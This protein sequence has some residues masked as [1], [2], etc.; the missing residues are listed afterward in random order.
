MTQNE[1]YCIINANVDFLKQKMILSGVSVITNDYNSTKIVFNFTNELNGTKIA[2]IRKEDSETTEALFAGEI[3]N[4][5]VILVAKKDVTT[6]HNE[7]TYTKYIDSQENIYWYNPLNEK[8]YNEEFV[9]QPSIS[10]ENL[11]KVQENASIFNEEGNYILE[12]TLYGEDSK[13]T[14]LYDTFSVEPEQ[15]TIGDEKAIV[16][17]PIFDTMLNEL[18]V[19]LDETNNLNIDAQKTDNK[20][21][22]TITKKDGTLNSVEILDGEKGDTG[23]GISNINKTST[24]GLI[25]TYTISYTDAPSTTFNVTN[26]ADGDDY[27]ITQQD[28]NAIAGVVETDIQPTIQNIQNTANNANSTANIA[29]GVASNANTTANTA[30]SIAE[31]ANQA[32]SY[33]NYSNMIT[34]FNALSSTTYRVGQNIYINTLEVPDLWIGSV[35]SSSSTYTYTTDE[36]FITALETNGYVQVGYYKLSAL[37]TQKVDLTNYATKDMFVTLTQTQ[38]DNLQTINP[39]VYYYIIEE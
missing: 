34:A 6:I 17:L 5:E 27:V 28:Y 30:K 21:I 31:G 37:E 13:L 4:N 36:A 25:D 29:S 18:N 19:A 22:I 9:E 3:I 15:I 1:N 32:L 33:S 12:V 11:T 39:D 24:S 38:Y 20:S 10:I 7:V 2:K 35:E 16:Y 23:N 14:S 8:V 26:G